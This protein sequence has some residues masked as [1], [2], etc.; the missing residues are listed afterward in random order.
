MRA[1]T[2]K[3]QF[4]AGIVI[5]TVTAIGS[6]A[7]PSSAGCAGAEAQLKA[8]ESELDRNELDAAQKLLSELQDAHPDCPALLLA[9]ARIQAAENFLA[10]ATRA[11]SEY[12]E[13]MPGDAIG[14]AYYAGFLFDRG[15][16]AQADQLSEEAYQRAPDSPVTAEIRG[17][18][19]A[20]KGESEK[21]RDLLEQSCAKDP[22][23][24][25]AHFY[26][27][28]IYNRAKRP[29]DAAVHFRRVVTLDSKFASAWDY[30]ALNLER[31]GNED[32]ADAAYH[33]GL[34]VN[35]EGQL[36]YDA[37][38]DY[39][40]GRFLAKR[41]RLADAKDHLDRAVQ[42]VPSYRATWY[43]RAKLYL[44]IG[45]YAQ[46]RDDGER[47]L[48]ITDQTGGILNLQVYVLLEQAYRR[49]GDTK[50]AEK[51]AVLTRETAPPVRKGY[52][53]QAQP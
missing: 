21:A 52:E 18:I 38:L 13:R 6:Q 3:P 40:Y 53:A 14:M 34:A 41:N 36:H 26:L 22:D 33:N 44:Q 17:Q 1:R 49:L 42:L 10:A 9:N 20:A 11:F 45:H 37:F 47:A 29:G 24:P 12:G 32:M 30:L 50:A 35:Q 31:L 25:K 27:G 7:Q 19:L 23:N 46:A 8:L 51:Y 43:D 2:V 48:S 5:A 15:Q 4:L 28:E 39:N 16:Y